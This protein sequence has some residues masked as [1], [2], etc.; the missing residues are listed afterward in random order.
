MQ[1]SLLK[2]VLRAISKN[3]MT[4]DDAAA[5][6][7]VSARQVNRLMQRYD[8]KRPPGAT[9]K[10]RAAAAKRKETRLRVQECTLA[11]IAAG[12]LTVEEAVKAAKVSERTIYRWLNSVK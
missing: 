4:R 12:A 11:A 6:L 7:E 3:E 1:A 10:A 5:E 8:V 9:H 2:K